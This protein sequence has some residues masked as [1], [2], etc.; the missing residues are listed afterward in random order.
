MRGYIQNEYVN[1]TFCSIYAGTQILIHTADMVI[2]DRI[3]F[4]GRPIALFSKLD[5]GRHLLID[6]VEGSDLTIFSKQ[7]EHRVRSLIATWS[8]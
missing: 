8:A 6:A 2:A 1:I 5:S 4:S 3:N 7:N